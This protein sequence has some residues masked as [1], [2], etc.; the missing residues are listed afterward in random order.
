MGNKPST[1]AGKLSG[2]RWHHLDNGLPHPTE[3]KHRIAS[4]LRSLKKLRGE[5]TGKHPVTPNQLRHIKSRLDLSNARHVV[6]WAAVTLGF[7][8]MMRCSEYLAE[9]NTFDPVRALTTD[10][11]TPHL[12]GVMLEQDDW[13]RADS[14][15][16]LFQISKTDQNRI[17]CTRTVFATGDDL[18]CAR[19][20][21]TRPCA[22]REATRGG[23]SSRSWATPKAGSS[24]AR[25]S[26]PR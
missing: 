23:R 22:R 3:G 11:L 13:A 19:S 4:A 18:I 12:N 9:G 20:R 15:T 5:G 6:K 24:T 7:F 26:R 8:L 21:R 25:R 1:V 10:K 14:L 2:I 17:G 16:A